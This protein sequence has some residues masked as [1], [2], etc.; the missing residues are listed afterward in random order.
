MPDT[1][2]IVDG[3][4]SMMDVL[5]KK[6]SNKKLS[7]EQIES[8]RQSVDPSKSE[9]KGTLPLPY[10]MEES[11]ADLRKAG[12]APSLTMETLWIILPETVDYEV[13]A[14]S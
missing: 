5:R 2:A 11:Y 6:K 8:A 12:L 7:D 3:A 13:I 14:I 4:P 10:F 9:L 1:R